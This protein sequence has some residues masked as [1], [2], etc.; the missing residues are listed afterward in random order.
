MDLLCS[1]FGAAGTSRR[2]AEGLDKPIKFTAKDL[3]PL[4]RDRFCA[5][6]SLSQWR[7]L[8]R[9]SELPSLELWR[10]SSQDTVGLQQLAVYAMLCL[11]G[12]KQA[13]ALHLLLQASCAC[14]CVPS[15]DPCLHTWQSHLRHLMVSAIDVGCFTLAGNRYGELNQDYGVSTV[16]VHKETISITLDLHQPRQTMPPS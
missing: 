7:V 14:R 13:K 8:A 6:G 9:C 12:G 10:R 16:A 2:L 5:C 1:T 3:A 4:R 15:L 11:Q